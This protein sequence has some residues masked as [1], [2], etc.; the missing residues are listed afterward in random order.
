MEYEG[1]L[2]D[3][4]RVGFRPIRPDDKQML[5]RGFEQLSEESRYRRFFRQ[6]DH[7]TDEQ[8]RYLTEVDFIDHYAWIAYLPDEAGEPGIAVGRWIRIPAE[9]EVAESAI[10]VIDAYQGN[11]LGS[12]MLWL[13][14]RSA[15][16][17]GVRAL[18]VWVQGDN[19]KVLAMLRDFGIIPTHWE[20]GVSEIDIPLPSVEGFSD[21]P[22]RILL[23][24]V[25]SGEIHAEGLG[26]GGSR[27][28][29]RDEKGGAPDRT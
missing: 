26:S 24:A 7:L 21:T 10:T 15:A 28:Q 29:L 16:E 8:L 25:A 13:L 17:K 23:R 18:R 1:S 12:T 5:V 3:G 19:S 2:P 22:A 14:A 20:G 11:G 9:P 27:T 6:I 4:T